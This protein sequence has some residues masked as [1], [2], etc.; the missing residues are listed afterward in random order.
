[1]IPI[2]ALTAWSTAVSA[3]SGGTDQYGCHAGTREYHCH[4]GGTLSP[5]AARLILQYYAEKEAQRRAELE[6]LNQARLAAARAADPCSKEQETE[7]NR[8]LSSR[9]DVLRPQLATADYDEWISI[10]KNFLQNNPWTPKQCDA[11]WGRGNRTSEPSFRAS[12]RKA[13]EKAQAQQAPEAQQAQSV[14]RMPRAHW[15]SDEDRLREAGYEPLSIFIADLWATTPAYLLADRSCKITIARPGMEPVDLKPASTGW[16]CFTI[17]IEAADFDQDGDFDLAVRTS[18]QGGHLGARYT[19][20]MIS[21]F[22]NTGS[23][24]TAKF[25]EQP[26]REWGMVVTGDPYGDDDNSIYGRQC[27]KASPLE[28]LGHVLDAER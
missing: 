6:Q 13:V 28:L 27:D 25:P 16:Q 19:V 3:H 21:T 2:L 8:V 20:C 15:A 14:L 11:R 23:S 5:D 18:S 26:A 17:D 1:V 22:E 24:E 10:H 12:L 9:Y 7:R 4:N